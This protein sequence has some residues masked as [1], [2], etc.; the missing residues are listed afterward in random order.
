MQADPDWRD[1]V[2]SYGPWAVL[3]GSWVQV[4]DRAVVGAQDNRSGNLMAGDLE[5]IRIVL[6]NTTH[7]GNIGATAR[8]M[9]VMGLS[10]LHL[11]T[12]AEFPNAQATAMASGADDLLRDARVHDSLDSALADPGASARSTA[13]A[14]SRPP[15]IA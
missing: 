6:I 1:L 9:K 11:V 7:S 4:F 5:N 10:S 14:A 12:P 3:A 15:V 8:A 13:R 2:R